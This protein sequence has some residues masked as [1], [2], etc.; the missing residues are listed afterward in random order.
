MPAPRLPQDLPS[1]A[2]LTEC[3]A[4]D[5]DSGALTWKERPAD[6]FPGVGAHRRFSEK[7]A[8]RL[9]GTPNVS[10][11]L[12]A[13]V[14][15]RSYFVHRLV[16]AIH[17]GQ[18]P[19]QLLDHINGKRD[20]NRIVNLRDVSSSV[21]GRGQGKKRNNTSGYNGITW[22]SKNNMWRAQV[23]FNGRGIHLGR[24]TNIADAVSAREKANESLNFSG[25]H[26]TDNPNKTP[27]TL[28]GHLRVNNSSGH[29]G[30][31]YS[32]KHWKAKIGVGG[33]EYHLGTFKTKEEAIAARKAAEIQYGVADRVSYGSGPAIL[34]DPPT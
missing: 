1:V 33:R 16:W 5:P 34:Q 23:M 24:F 6:H 12:V 17:Y 4:Y 25:Y 9:A 8:G 21:N 28:S 32:G 30:I 14:S 15:G 22:D 20:D 19:E 29:V 31:R 18:Y 3:F 7:W 27:K 11:Y 13:Y 2:Y 26:G 10:G